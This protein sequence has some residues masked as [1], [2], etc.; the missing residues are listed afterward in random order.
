MQ[1]YEGYEWV[2]TL[3][4]HA[5]IRLVKRSMVVSAQAMALASQDSLKKVALTRKWR[6]RYGVTDV[7]R[8]RFSIQE[9]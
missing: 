5:L 6:K 9:K 3:V 8:D 2:D 4:E 1:A 7:N